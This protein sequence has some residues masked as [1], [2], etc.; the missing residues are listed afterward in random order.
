MSTNVKN[1]TPKEFLK[2]FNDILKFMV[3][4]DNEKYVCDKFLL[5]IV[6]ICQESFISGVA[7]E[8]AI[9]E[10]GHNDMEIKDKIRMFIDNRIGEVLSK[11][12]QVWKDSRLVSVENK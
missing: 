6:A 10:T 5:L 12:I 9:V 11:A 4:S 3:E 2:E 8:S 7:C 1:L